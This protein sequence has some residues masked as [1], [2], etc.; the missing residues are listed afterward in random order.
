MTPPFNPKIS[1]CFLVTG[2]QIRRLR[3]A[4]TQEEAQEIVERMRL[5]KYSGSADKLVAA[6]RVR[7]NQV[8]IQED[9][10]VELSCDAEDGGAR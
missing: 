2:G 4:A 1:D 3:D 10:E 7:T 6:E 9:T 5:Q 8:K